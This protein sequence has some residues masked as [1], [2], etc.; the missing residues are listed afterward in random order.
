MKE[1]RRKVRLLALA[2]VA[3]ILFSLP[4]HAQEAEEANPAA[5]LTA[6]LVAAALQ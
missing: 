6:A 2:L 3:G 4:A 5:A 1:T